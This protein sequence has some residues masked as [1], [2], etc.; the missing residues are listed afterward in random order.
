MK[1]TNVFLITTCIMV[2][3][4]FYL[5]AEIMSPEV[6]QVQMDGDSAVYD[7]DTITDVYVEIGEFKGVNSEGELLFPGVFLK[8]DMLFV[9]T[10]IR[11]YGIDTPEKRPLHAGRTPES[12]EREKVA[13]AKARE[14]LLKLVV[15][16]DYVFTIKNPQLGKYAGR[17][18]AE[19]YFDEINVAEYMIEEGHAKPYDG[20]KKIPFDEW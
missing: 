12:I 9:V 14:A 4:W 17:I 19:V 15:E 6:Y 7:G 16:N 11:I 3:A 13:A 18:V 10:D 8:G 2:V 5:C 20:G 1:T